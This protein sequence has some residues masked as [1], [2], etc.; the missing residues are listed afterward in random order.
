MFMETIEAKYT[1]FVTSYESQFPISQTSMSTSAGQSGKH[2][3]ERQYAQVKTIPDDVEVALHIDDGRWSYYMVDRQKQM[4]FWIDDFIWN[5][6][7][8]SFESSE[9]EIRYK[10]Q[11]RK[12]QIHL[13]LLGHI[14]KE[15]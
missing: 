11:A 5:D 3:V 14:L 8:K 6:D 12:L 13:V 7:I 1:K 4:V 15:I 9:L 2:D 10:E